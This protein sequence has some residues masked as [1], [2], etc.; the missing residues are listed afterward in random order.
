[1]RTLG[2]HILLLALL[3]FLATGAGATTATVAVAAEQ[4]VDSSEFCGQRK[5]PEVG[6]PKTRAINCYCSLNGK[7]SQAKQTLEPA[8]EAVKIIKL[9][10]PARRFRQLP[11]SLWLL[12]LTTH[13]SSVPTPPPRS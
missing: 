12:T 13:E 8:V 4:S 7:K 10:R 5:P 11:E 1:M 9:P 6:C 2:L 3:A